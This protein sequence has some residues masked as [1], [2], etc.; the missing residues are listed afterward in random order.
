M[1]YTPDPKT[2][3]RSQ[4]RKFLPDHE[5]VKLF[6]RLFEQAG[7]LL[8]DEKADK[9]PTPVNNDLADLDSTGNLIDSGIQR[10]WING[11]RAVIADTTFTLSDGT[12]EADATA[13]NIVVTLFSA[14]TSGRPGAVTKTDATPHTVTLRCAGADTWPDGST[15]QSLLAQGEVLDFQANA[16]GNGMVFK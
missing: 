1:T 2:P 14:S 9:V 7:R 6:E 13:G 5:T 8:Q 11:I 12:I 16:T 10:G 3:T 4:L 15:D